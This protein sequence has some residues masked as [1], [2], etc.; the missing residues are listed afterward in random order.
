MSESGDSGKSSLQVIL[1]QAE[2]MHSRLLENSRALDTKGSILLAL[3]GLL[4]VKTLDDMELVRTTENYLLSV[5]LGTS[6]LAMLLCFWAIRLHGFIHFRLGVLQERYDKGE[7]ADRIM[8]QLF[9]NFREAA[10]DSLRI[11]KRKAQLLALAYW[12]TLI[13]ILAFVFSELWRRF[14]H[15]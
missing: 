12:L 15:G 4:L 10:E 1:A 9:A 8:A 13:A 14:I 7:S 11:V 6:F 5:A 3:L 2:W